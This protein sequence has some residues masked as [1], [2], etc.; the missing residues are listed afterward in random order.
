[1]NGILF[2]IFVFALILF[3]CG[4]NSISLYKEIN[5]HSNKNLYIDRKAMEY[6]IAKTYE[7][8]CCDYYFLILFSMFASI[9]IL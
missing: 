7:K 4:Y 6:S 5:P 1:M 2:I 3:H 8:H 9:I